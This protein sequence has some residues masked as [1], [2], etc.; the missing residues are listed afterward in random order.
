MQHIHL[1]V[2][3]PIVSL[4]TWRWWSRFCSMKSI[5]RNNWCW[6]S[7]V[8][9]NQPWT[10][11]DAM[12]FPNRSLRSVFITR[13]IINSVQIWSSNFDILDVHLTGLFIFTFNTHLSNLNFSHTHTPFVQC[14]RAVKFSPA[15]ITFNIIL[16]VRACLRVSMYSKYITAKQKGRCIGV[17]LSS[18]T[19][20]LNRIHEE[21]KN[22]FCHC[23]GEHL[24]LV[25]MKI[26]S[27]LY[28][29]LQKKALRGKIFTWK[30]C[31]L[32]LQMERWCTGFFIVAKEKRRKNK[33][34]H[35]HTITIHVFRGLNWKFY[36]MKNMNMNTQYIRCSERHT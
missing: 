18:R 13:W 26:T 12:N 8:W 27:S 4:L 14:T 1:M 20:K 28:H 3:N 17:P 33:H 29:T 11:N 6:C 32:M 23:T 19:Q 25:F 21:R 16:I 30:M 5:R 9:V 31:E 7:L 34:I 15:K 2:L 35:I 22:V 24:F 36:G 10:K